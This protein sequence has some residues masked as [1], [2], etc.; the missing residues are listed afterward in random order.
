M[1]KFTWG[2]M[3]FT[4]GA[5]AEPL[6][7]NDADQAAE[8]AAAAAA[9]KTMCD[10]AGGEDLARWQQAIKHLDRDGVPAALRSSKH[11]MDVVLVAGHVFGLP[12]AC[13][14]AAADAVFDAKQFLAK[15]SAPYLRTEILGTNFGQLAIHANE[16]ESFDVS[17]CGARYAR[18]EWKFQRGQTSAVVLQQKPGGVSIERCL[19]SKAAQVPTVAASAELTMS[20]GFDD[21]DEGLDVWAAPGEAH[22]PHDV[23]K[24]RYA[25]VRD[26]SKCGYKLKPK[27]VVVELTRNMSGRRYTIG[28]VDNDA[29]ECAAHRADELVSVYRS[30]DN[31]FLSFVVDAAAVTSNVVATKQLTMLA[32]DAC[33]L[34]DVPADERAARLKLIGTNIPYPYASDA[35]KGW[36]A[37]A[38]LEA[39]SKLVDAFASLA[40][41][42]GVACPALGVDALPPEDIEPVVS[43][44]AKACESRFDSEVGHVADQVG[45]LQKQHHRQHGRYAS[46]AEL[47]A[48]EWWT[49]PYH[50]EVNVVDAGAD[51]MQVRLTGVG[52]Y[53]GDEWEFTQAW[54]DTLKQTKFRRQ[55]L[56]CPRKK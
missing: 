32:Q 38:Q 24:H 3:L 43:L 27:R 36:V 18:I 46:T 53:R 19:L 13:E 39:G 37:I 40:R 34:A 1:M 49:S 22:A 29:A 14:G 9:L 11:L 28:D 4:M 26:L 16:L 41:Q 56:P 6:V 47:R 2:V 42:Q 54:R 35:V 12:V 30:S 5:L 8:R 51:K 23:L 31:V 17:S 50:F 33:R 10:D 44:R 48:M 52:A 45:S 20:H 15:A 25:F 55:N 21:V 7:R